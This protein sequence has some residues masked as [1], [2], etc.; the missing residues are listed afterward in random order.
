MK[1]G[2]ILSQI[3]T[4][5]DLYE[6]SKNNSFDIYEYNVLINNKEEIRNDSLTLYKCEHFEANIDLN[7]I[8]ANANYIDIYKSEEILSNKLI[9]TSFYKKLI[10]EYKLSYCR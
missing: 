1:S 6:I 3:N 2:Y 10:N 9:K 5:N 8:K 7:I 4:L